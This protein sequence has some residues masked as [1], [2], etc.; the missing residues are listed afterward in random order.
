MAYYPLDGNAGNEAALSSGRQVSSRVRQFVHEVGL[1]MAV[2]SIPVRQKCFSKQARLYGAIRRVLKTQNVASSRLINCFK[3]GDCKRH[4]RLT[5][6]SS[7]PRAIPSTRKH[8]TVSSTE[9]V[10]D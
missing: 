7:A 10:S 1:I 2:L 4:N 8:S 9:T 5:H 6:A 3:H